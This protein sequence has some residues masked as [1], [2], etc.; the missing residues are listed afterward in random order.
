MS[1]FKIIN[2]LDKIF[3]SICVFLLMFAWINF[4]LHDLWTSFF[5]SIIFS[6]A[7]LFLIFCFF[8]K[9]Q[10]KIAL[11]KKYSQDIEQNFLAFRLLRQNDKL[12]LIKQLISKTSECKIKN[13][14]L[15]FFNEKK[16]QL[17][18]SV[19]TTSFDENT[20]FEMIEKAEKGTECLMIICNN[21]PSGINTKILKNLE[22]KFIDKKELYDN[23]F[24]KYSL[25]PDTQNLNLSKEK[26]TLKMIIKN[27]IIPAKAKSYFW[28][29]IVLLFSSIILP[30]RTYYL[31]FGSL[32]LIFS[33]LSKLQPHFRH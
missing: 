4:F 15:L 12:N 26:I 27:L 28:C 24:F 8:N 14:S 3:V 32:F 20:L 6:S 33:I 31:I 16:C 7:C 5:I 19:N 22:I 30:Y 18:I 25:F 21:T 23:Y 9:R 1:R 11:N 29:G 2:L 13:G 10:T 17:F